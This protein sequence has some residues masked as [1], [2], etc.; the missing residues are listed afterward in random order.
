LSQAKEVALA[1][2]IFLRQRNMLA[3][4]LA[5]PRMGVGTAVRAP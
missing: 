3:S 1:D 4:I 2:K 5:P